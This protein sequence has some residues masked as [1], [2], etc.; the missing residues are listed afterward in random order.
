MGR[1]PIEGTLEAREFI[2]SGAGK[3][4][5]NSCGVSE[6]AKN[7]IEYAVLF[8][9]GLYKKP[10]KRDNTDTKTEKPTNTLS[11]QKKVKTEPIHTKKSAFNSEGDEY[12]KPEDQYT[13]E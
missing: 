1:K 4:W 9:L 11:K 13:V 12:F 3:E 8:G 5:L 7:R 6:D 10:P 2:Q